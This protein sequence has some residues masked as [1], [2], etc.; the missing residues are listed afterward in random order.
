MRLTGAL[1]TTVL[2]AG[3]LV[4]IPLTQAGAVD[5]ACG[6]PPPAEN[7]TLVS[8][9]WAQELYDPVNKISPFSAGAGV[10]VAVIDSGV[11][12]A[13]Q[14]LQGNLL[15]G[16][17]FFREVVGGNIDCA[18]Y[19]TGVASI[20]AAQS[21]EGIGFAGLAPGATIL[22][23]RIS[24]KKHTSPSDDLLPP[25]AI[26]AG[27]D[28]AVSSGATVITVSAVTFRDEARLA[29][30]VIR[31]LDAGVLIVAAAGDGHEASRDEERVTPSPSYPASYDGVVGVGAVGEDGMRAPTSQIGTYVDLVAPGVNVIAAG[32]TGHVGYNGTSFAAGFVAAT[33]ALMLG[34]PGSDLAGLGGRERVRVLTER[35]FGTAD[36]TPGAAPSLAYGHGLVDPGRAM[37]EPL[38]ASG[39]EE[40]GS[41]RP[42]PRD[43][44][45]EQLAAE[46]A[47]AEDGALFSTLILGGLALAVLAAAFVIPRARRRRWRAGRERAATLANEEDK[48]E[49]YLPGEMLFRPAKDRD[50][51]E[52]DKVD[53]T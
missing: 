46:R 35:L 53:Q 21:V 40:L 36:G 9:P 31:A 17:D 39:P 26:A 30:A 14:Q 5:P 29:E 19:G 8:L 32:L 4:L 28:Y 38:G 48:R 33:A 3:G 12:G 52:R 13:H 42:P 16:Y 23:I 51:A 15:A 45:A 20:I 25:S 34:R 47:A 27:I 49:E 44:A 11:D 2:V 22:P 41:R 1:L 24:E 18:P 7:E 6:T 37:S 43:L 50:S 10:T